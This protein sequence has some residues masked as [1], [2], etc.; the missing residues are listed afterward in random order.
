MGPH[1]RYFILD[2]QGRKLGCLLFCQATRSLGC[3]DEWIG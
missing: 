3:R 2:R 1:I